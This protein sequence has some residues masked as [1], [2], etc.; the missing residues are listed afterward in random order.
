MAPGSMIRL[1]YTEPVWQDVEKRFHV[2]EPLDLIGKTLHLVV[3]VEGQ[4]C[5][6]RFA[7]GRDGKTEPYADVGEFMLT[8]QP[9]FNTFTFTV[10]QMRTLR[11]SPDYSAL[12]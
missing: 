1:T 8:A 3:I 11:G 9:G 10:E 6:L 5:Q 4:A 7:A 2:D 12:T